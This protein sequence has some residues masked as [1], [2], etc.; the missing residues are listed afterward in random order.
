MKK[1]SPHSL[2]P[3]A[4]R[5][6]GLA[7]SLAVSFNAAAQTTLTEGH[8][9]VG[10]V[11]E[12]N[13]W[14][15]HIGRHDDIPP[16]E[17]TPA[18]AILQVGPAGQTTVPA[19]PAYGFLGPVGSLV[20]I[21]PQAENPALLFLGLGTEEQA[22]GVFVGDRLTLSLTGVAG[23][24]QFSMYQVGAF[25][26]PTVLMNSADGITAADKV[27]LTAPGH[28]HVN[29][30]FTAP[31]EYQVAFRA[32][33]VLDDGLNTFTQSVPTTYT[34]S[35][36]PEPGSFALFGLGALVFIAARNPRSAQA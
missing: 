32:S 2:T 26:T 7:V 6:L 28:A 35:V 16:M 13:Q 20:Y 30:A 23:P 25:G 17:Y 27:E 22:S 18:E 19:N 1:Y 21:L 31:G 11:Y 4:I 29:W 9:D 24:G 12:A 3:A 34:F 14:N 33:G 15:L 8:T 10:I 36:V 5:Q